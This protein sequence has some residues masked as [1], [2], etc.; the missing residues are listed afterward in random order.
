MP[1]KVDNFLGRNYTKSQT[2][3]N[4]LFTSYT[5]HVDMSVVFLS[6]EVGVTI[7]HV[8][9]DQKFQRHVRDVVNFQTSRHVTV[10]YKLT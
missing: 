2:N 10:T 5:R 1:A 3:Q 8:T 9:L 6:R 7:R 4:R